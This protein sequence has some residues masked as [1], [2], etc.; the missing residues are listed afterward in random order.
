MNMRSDDEKKDKLCSFRASQKDKVLI[1]ENAR[2]AGLNASEYMLR[3]CI[4][5]EG[6]ITPEIMVKLQDITNFVC[7]LV[8]EKDSYIAGYLREEVKTLWSLLK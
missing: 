2:K 5:T 3:R 6:H 4:K 1:E 8:P 7:S